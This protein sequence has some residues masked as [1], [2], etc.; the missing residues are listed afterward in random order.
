MEEIK[1]GTPN[2]APVESLGC[3]PYAIGGASFIPLVGIPF[4]IIAIIW[5]I[6]T[7]KRGRVRLITLGICG[8]MLTCLLYGSLFYLGFVQRGGIYDRLR[9]EL[10]K[11][12]LP[13]LVKEIE[14]Y[15]LKTGKYPEALDVLLQDKTS[16]FVTIYDPHQTPLTDP[17]TKF[18]YE[19]TPDKQ[20]YYLR[21]VG[22]DKKPFTDDDIIPLFTPEELKHIGLLIKK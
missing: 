7:K 8:I 16:G 17:A 11:T 10:A 1:E 2:V 3:L 14:F 19:L 13:M 9:A 6:G 4:G 5:G 20:H 12:M 15:K 18:Y 21:S 22:L